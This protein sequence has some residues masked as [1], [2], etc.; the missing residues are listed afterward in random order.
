[1]SDTA[2][3]TSEIISIHVQARN[4]YLIEYSAG[5][6]ELVTWSG[7]PMP[8]GVV[9]ESPLLKGV[10]SK[11]C[12]LCHKGMNI[13]YCYIWPTVLHRGRVSGYNRKEF[14][15]RP[16]K[17][18]CNECKKVKMCGWEI[19]HEE[20][21]VDIVL[22][23]PDWYIRY[24]MTEGPVGNFSINDRVGMYSSIY[25]GGYFNR[26]VTIKNKDLSE[27]ITISLSDLDGDDD[28]RDLLY[29]AI[30]GD[31]HIEDKCYILHDWK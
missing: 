20:D 2:Q 5:E 31:F 22:D 10:S 24:G 21:V 18:E 29:R 27:S 7:L 9:V 15:E 14:F 26:V 17:Y 6:P 8:S 1:M 23:P 12:P 19:H 25:D 4:K 3:E 16:E 13:L 28:A 30:K 11:E